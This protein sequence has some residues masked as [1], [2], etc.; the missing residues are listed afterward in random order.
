[1]S[2]I[3]KKYKFI[4]L[5][6]YKQNFFKLG[7]EPSDN[8]LETETDFCERCADSFTSNASPAGDYEVK[9][10]EVIGDTDPTAYVLVLGRKS[11]GNKIP[12]G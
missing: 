12:I 10:S 5:N 11:N 6:S 9:I 4:L 1:M 8:R 7:S 2:V 3:F